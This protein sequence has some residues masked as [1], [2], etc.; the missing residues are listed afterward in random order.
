V[1]PRWDVA[2]VKEKLEKF[3]F[4]TTVLTASE[5]TGLTNF[6]K[7]WTAFLRSVARD[8]EI[9]IVYSGHGIDIR[10]ANYLVPSDSPKLSDMAGETDAINYLIPLDKL[11]KDLEEHQVAI[12]VWLIDA[13]RENPFEGNGKRIG[14]VGGMA[15]LNTEARNSEFL[16]FS[17]GFG[18]IARDSLPNDGP[19]DHGSPYI[20]TF[21][22][23]FDDY[24]TKLIQ[25]FGHD[26]RD[27]VKKLVAPDPQAPIYVDGVS[28]S[29]CFDS[30]P[31]ESATVKVQ[32]MGAQK[33]VSLSVTDTASTAHD[34]INDLVGTQANAV[35]LAKKSAAGCV[36]GTLSNNYP[37]GCSL[38]KALAGASDYSPFIGRPLVAELGVNVRKQVP[39]VKPSGDA[40]FSCTVDGVDPGQSIR[41]RGVVSVN[42]LSDTFYWGI[43]PGVPKSCSQPGTNDPFSIKALHESSLTKYLVN[44][45]YFTASDSSNGVPRAWY[46]EDYIYTSKRSV[47][48]V[49]GAYP[50]VFK[51][52]AFWSADNKICSKHLIIRIANPDA[53]FGISRG[54][55]GF[56]PADW[57]RLSIGEIKIGSGPPSAWKIVGIRF[58]DMEFLIAPSNGSRVVED[59]VRGAVKVSDLI[60]QGET[61]IS[62][63]SGACN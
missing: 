1:N 40:Q 59:D 44:G 41:I 50:N 63:E 36:I 4:K 37:F 42:Y 10:S 54:P 20:R 49:L 55:S 34:R 30:C 25:S 61:D 5:D 45:H 33:T 53:E 16:F 60:S 39:S 62:V 26:I 57:Y 58:S 32:T 28:G 2:L 17:A 23:M 9:V 6:R 43:L 38:A 48:M 11:V 18:Q 15:K 19:N 35:Y 56:E 21:V 8:D 13:C 52:T 27:N 12:Q 31:L 47:G 14:S 29:W 7:N 46:A 3:R 22:K 24:S 51:L